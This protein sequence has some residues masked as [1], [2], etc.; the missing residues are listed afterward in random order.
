M[1]ETPELSAIA[2][3]PLSVILIVPAMS[4]EVEAAFNDW[5][6]YLNGLDRDYEI[7]LVSE[8][9]GT[10]L[11]DLAKQCAR[12]HAVPAAGDGFGAALYAGLRAA[13]QPLVCYTTCDKQ[14]KPQDL[15]H[16]LK[17]IDKTHLVSGRRVYPAGTK[18]SGWRDWLFRLLVRAVF[19]IRLKDVECRFVLARRAIFPR[20]PI[21]SDG[22]FAHVEL[23]AKSNFLGQIMADAP[24]EYRPPSE[25]SRL[26][27]R[28]D[29]QRVYKR[30]DFGPVT[31][32][33][34]AATNT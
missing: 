8:R 5:V 15:R 21:Q 11:D 2:A 9:A 6:S 27:W 17:L 26:P 28:G 18:G 19:G 33:D 10:A 3:S 16:L 23:L 31:V 32:P 13:Q 1:I 29:F 12:A 7:V 4:P 34:F 25:E 14:F 22:P 24:V 30:P 20:I